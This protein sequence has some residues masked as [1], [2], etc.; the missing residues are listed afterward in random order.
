MRH[1]MNLLLATLLSLAAAPLPA[2][3]KGT[4]DGS[5]TNLAFTQAANDPPVTGARTVQVVCGPGVDCA[6]VRLVTRAAPDVPWSVVVANGTARFT[7]PAGAPAGTIAGSYDAFTF[8]VNPGGP[9]GGSV[10]GAGAAVQGAASVCLYGSDEMNTLLD[11]LTKQHADSAVV[12]VDSLGHVLRLPRRAIDEGEPVH[13]Y[14]IR[15]SDPRPTL[16]IRRVSAF[17]EMETYP[18]IGEQST[19]ASLNAADACRIHQYVLL[20][21]FRGGV[22]GQISINRAETKTDGSRDTTRLG[23]VEIAVRRTYRGALSLGVVRSGLEDPDVKAVGP[24]STVVTRS[25]G[26]RYL[27]TLFFTPFYRRRAAEDWTRPIYEYVTPQ[28]GVVVNDIRSNILYGLTAEIPSLGLFVGAGGHTGRVTRIPAD[29]PL[30]GTNLRGTGRSIE[31][32]EVWRTD[33]YIS[34][35]LD[36]RAASTFLSRITK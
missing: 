25:E 11:T 6:R 10:G 3:I 31:T 5:G 13:V 15:G 30:T 28:V 12:I 14:A 2:Q 8:S 21:N 33:Y 24:D 22:A 1:R 7:E 26:E 35:S 16:S 34:V 9:V 29:G 20:E 23:L 17:R 18:I 32:E 27:Y 4:L 36:L 19:I